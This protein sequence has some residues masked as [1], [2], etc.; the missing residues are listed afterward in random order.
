VNLLFKQLSSQNKKSIKIWLFASLF[1]SLQPITQ[2]INKLWTIT[3]RTI[4]IR[5]GGGWRARQLI[6]LPLKPFH[7]RK[8]D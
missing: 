7:E 5:K 1:V 2:I 6:P 8:K 4:T 3:R